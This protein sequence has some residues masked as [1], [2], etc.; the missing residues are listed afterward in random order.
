MLTGE[1]MM[2]NTTLPRRRSVMIATVVALVV[3]AGGGAWGLNAYRSAQVTKEARALYLDA[4]QARE[5]LLAAGEEYS[6]VA[7]EVNGRLDTIRSTAEL[8]SANSDFFA[9]EPREAVEQALA[10]VNS[11]VDAPESTE[12]EASDET[13]E[14]F[15]ERFRGAD[16]TGRAALTSQVQTDSQ[17]FA[18]HTERLNTARSD[19]EA[20]AGA[21]TEALLVVVQGLTS[22]AERL[23]TQ[24]SEA[25][26]KT[27]T[28]LHSAAEASSGWVDLSTEEVADRLQD[29]HVLIE[30]HVGAALAHRDSHADAVAAREKAAR[31][32]AARK[33]SGGSSGGGGG[34]SQGLCNVWRW[35]PVTGGYMSL[36]PC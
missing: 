10:Q 9:E 32:A 29:L 31:E 16:E 2:K 24:H 21:L 36:E 12:F 22:D 4:Q 25:D 1:S 28:A 15:I 26:E 6:Q 30:A 35:A 7:D 18:A 8:M 23:V 20:W 17:T 19:L 13:E 14:D 11:V 27:V 5:T 33:R 3:A 34:G